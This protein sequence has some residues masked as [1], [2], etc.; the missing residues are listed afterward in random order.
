MWK[1]QKIFD[2]CDFI[3]IFSFG[4]LLVLLNENHSIFIDLLIHENS[5]VK[6]QRT[7]A[8]FVFRCQRLTTKFWVCDGYRRT[9]KMRTKGLEQFSSVHV[10]GRLSQRAIQQKWRCSRL[11]R[12]C[13]KQTKNRSVHFKKVYVQ[14]IVKIK[15]FTAH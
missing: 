5:T 14:L 2:Y 13:T 4:E 12:L 15:L 6:V 9:P 11:L 1:R 10:I 7:M 8:F 3:N